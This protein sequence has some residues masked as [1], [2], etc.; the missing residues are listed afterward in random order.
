MCVKGCGR[1][2]RRYVRRGDSVY[3]RGYLCEM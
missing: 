2:V 1:G 3:M